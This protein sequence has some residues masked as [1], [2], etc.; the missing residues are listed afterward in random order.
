[1]TVEPGD[2]CPNCGKTKYGDLDTI[3]KAR[4]GNLMCR[5]CC[6]TFDNDK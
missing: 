6:Q 5:T 3:C 2:E 1:M 4:A